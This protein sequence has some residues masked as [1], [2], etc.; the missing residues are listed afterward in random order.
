[1]KEITID[2][3]INKLNNANNVMMFNLANQW[4]YWYYDEYKLYEIDNNLIIKQQLEDNEY[5]IHMFILDDNLTLFN[6]YNNDSNCVNLTVSIINSIPNELDKY[7]GFRCY[8]N[9]NK[10]CYQDK[11]CHSNIKSLSL[12]D[13]DDILIFCEELMKQGHLS[14]CEAISFKM[15]IDNYDNFTKLLGYYIDNK[16]VGI[17]TYRLFNNYGM[18][19]DIGVLESYRKQ[20]IGKSLCESVLTNNANVRFLYQSAK[21]NVE[22][23]ALAK[24]IGFEFIGARE[25]F[26]KQKR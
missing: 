22:S 13:R 17:V 20:G 18:I 10:N 6:E 3:F 23:T 16:L 9:I 2:E 25:L 7:L 12:D 8:S 15:C 21:Q 4:K 19:E 1:M 11:N 5:E 14:K 26:I 24:S